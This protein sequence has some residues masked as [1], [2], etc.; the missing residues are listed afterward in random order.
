M[1]KKFIAQKEE[2]DNVI[3]FINNEVEKDVDR[4]TLMKIDVVIEEIFVNIASYAYKE[5][6]KGF[7]D[8][9]IKNENNKIIISFED[10]GVP[11]NPLLKEDP[12]VTLSAENREPGGLG[13]YM[14]KKMMDNVEYIYKDNKN[15]LV[16]EKNIDM[17]E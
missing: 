8:I 12:D 15:I 6:E 9:S 11:F 14:M 4:K 2:L 3:E 5:E 10:M 16:I 1:K 13:I 17:E 7:V